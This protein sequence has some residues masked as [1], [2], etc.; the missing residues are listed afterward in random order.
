MGTVGEIGDIEVL[1]TE[2]FLLT[3]LK[4]EFVN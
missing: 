3:Q 4:L 2:V 1:E